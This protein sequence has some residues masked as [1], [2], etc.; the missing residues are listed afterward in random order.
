[1]F[2]YLGCC[3]GSYL[4]ICSDDQGKV[5]SQHFNSVISHSREDLGLLQY[6][7]LCYVSTLLSRE[8]VKKTLSPINSV[9]DDDDVV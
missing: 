6:F 4:S 2:F 3:C 1:M 7:V 5:D 9:H 8:G